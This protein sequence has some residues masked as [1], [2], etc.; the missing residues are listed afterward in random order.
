[1]SGCPNEEIVAYRDGN[2]YSNDPVKIAKMKNPKPV[3]R[4]LCDT[5]YRLL[6]IEHWNVLSKGIKLTED[7]EHD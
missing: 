5:M 4:E 6:G 2:F 3:T 7:T 1:M